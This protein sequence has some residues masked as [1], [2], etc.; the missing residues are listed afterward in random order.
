MVAVGKMVKPVIVL[1]VVAVAAYL[2]VATVTVPRVR[3]TKRNSL[4]M[5]TLAE[6]A[7]ELLALPMEGTPSGVVGLEVE[8][9]TTL[10]KVVAPFGVLVAVVAVATC[11]PVIPR[12]LVLKVEPMALT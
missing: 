1:A 7:R 3:L 6:V 4:A 12:K 11:D 9:P 2:L 10:K 5:T 8:G